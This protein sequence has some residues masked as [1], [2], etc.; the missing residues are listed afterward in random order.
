MSMAVP[1]VVQN[2]DIMSLAFPQ[3]HNKKFEPLPFQSRQ[4]SFGT[5]SLLQSF[6]A[7]MK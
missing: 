2:T 5:N 7:Q 3:Q 4:A 1:R 6:D